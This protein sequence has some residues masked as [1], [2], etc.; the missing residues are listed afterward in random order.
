[1]AEPTTTPA[2]SLSLKNSASTTDLPKLSRP[3][4]VDRDAQ[5][6]AS[7]NQDSIDKDSSNESGSLDLLQEN[8][9]LK[10]EIKPLSQE[11][12]Q[13]VQCAKQAEKGLQSLHVASYDIIKGKRNRILVLGIRCNQHY[14]A[15]NSN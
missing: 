14:I 7:L 15:S 5:L 12:R 9:L 11:I 3:P 13:A 4:R 6:M 2:S 1:M 8:Q 10:Q